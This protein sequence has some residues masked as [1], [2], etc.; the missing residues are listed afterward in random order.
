MASMPHP[1]PAS[2]GHVGPVVDRRK[3]ARLSVLLPGTLTLLDGEFG[4]AIE[5]IS[6]TGARI[7]TDARLRVG[8]EA[9]LRSSP[10]DELCS[11]AWVDGHAAG[12]QFVEEVPLGLIR[13]LRW[14]NDR[15]RAQHDADV[16]ALLSGWM[17]GGR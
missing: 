6:Q 17:T 3:S 11:V 4:C 2:S 8:R 14:H 15:N 10:L 1:D 13:Q 16:R 7:V 12:V 9:L 5:D